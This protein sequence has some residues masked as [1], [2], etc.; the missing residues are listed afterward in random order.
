MK[1]IPVFLTLILLTSCG[2]IVPPSTPPAVDSKPTALPTLTESPAPESFAVIGYFPDYRE[3]N[4]VWADSLTDIIYFSA[5]PRADGTLNTS[6]LSEDTWQGLLQL[7]A[8]RGLRLHLSIGGWERSAG[9]APMTADLLTRKNFIGRLTE[10]A[11][12]HNLD[13]VDF[14]WEFPENDTE[15][16]NY[17]LLLTEAKQAF[18]KHNLLVSVALTP[19]PSFPL[20]DFAIVDRVHLM[21]YDR[22]AKHSTFE[23]AMD[24]TQLFLDVG[25]PAEKI[26]LGVPFYGRNTSPPYKVLSYKEIITRYSPSPAID[27]VDGVYFNGLDTIQRK[28][29]FALEENLGGVMVWELAHDT[30]DSNSLLQRM[31]MLVKQKHPC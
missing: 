1:L 20:A 5:E 22:A 6:R 28:V 3:L 4:P 23:Q 24:D 10:F 17:I 12:A 16:D 15:F 19:D 26:I 18:A 27:E 25:I 21:S 7:K 29:C 31:Y 2:Q 9:F 13:G 11:L 30:T 14:D 8:E